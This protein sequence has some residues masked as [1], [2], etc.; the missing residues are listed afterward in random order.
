LHETRFVVFTDFSGVR[1]KVAL[2]ENQT[3]YLIR[4]VRDLNQLKEFLDL[5]DQYEETT[6]VEGF[7]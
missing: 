5:L 4:N 2:T 7:E 3:L 6:G 1:Y